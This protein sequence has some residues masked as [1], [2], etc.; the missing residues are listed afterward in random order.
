MKKTKIFC[1]LALTICLASTDA[2]LPG[3]N[4]EAAVRDLITKY[5]YTWEQGGASHVIQ[6]NADGTGKE[7]DWTFKWTL[8]NTKEVEANT[9]DTHGKTARF[10][11]WFDSKFD[12]YHGIYRLRDDQGTESQIQG[13]Q[14]LPRQ[15]PPRMPNMSRPPGVPPPP[16]GVVETPPPASPEMEQRAADIFRDYQ[17]DFV[18]AGRDVDPYHGFVVNMGKSDF[19]ITN[20]YTLFR[21]NNAPFK[22]LNGI[23]V[24][25]D[26]AGSIA[27]GLDIFAIVVPSGQ[28]TL[29]A[30]SHVDANV[31]VGDAVA[32]LGLK[33]NPLKK[34][35]IV[36]EIYSIE[37]D[38][39]KVTS[40]PGYWY[41]GSPIIHLKTG[42]VIG[43]VDGLTGTDT[44]GLTS[45]GTPKL[46]RWRLGYRLD[47][48]KTWQPI[49]W[50]LFHA[51]EDEMQRIETLSAQLNV[52]SFEFRRNGMAIT[53][54]HYTFPALKARIDQWLAAKALPHLDD[55]GQRLADAN[56]LS[57]LILMCQPD[58]TAARPHMTYDNFQREL[59]LEQKV[60]D[61][62]VNTFGD[63]K[64]NTG[65]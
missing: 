41:T 2:Q 30:M 24:P 17:S 62:L 42:Q 31:A 61:N 25:L 40:M 11:L 48:V 13:H 4:D 1:L 64:K 3:A 29:E 12:S 47:T 51:Q 27:V 57:S 37:P 34:D 56:F 35:M 45:D 36:G 32:A 60:R 10:H 28:K 54:S 59:D 46:A 23:E 7:D 8:V 49:D 55:A 22:R 15:L 43:V 58:I 65:L 6:F 50:T 26:G 14:K 20:A 53:V 33:L 5:P 19:L 44:D 18:S 38:R 39:I 16:Q 52:L 21:R 63:I 9:I